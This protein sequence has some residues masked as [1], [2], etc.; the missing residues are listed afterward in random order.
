MICFLCEEEKKELDYWLIYSSQKRELTICPECTDSLGLLSDPEVNWT[1]R[2]GK[3]SSC[4]TKINIIE[5]CIEHSG[6]FVDIFRT[7]HCFR[8]CK[9]CYDL[10]IEI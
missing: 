10:H 3:C 5:W 9:P 1:I 4:R 2:T 7:N 6:V 8:I